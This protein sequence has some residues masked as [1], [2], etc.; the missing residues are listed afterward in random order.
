MSFARAWEAVC[1]HIDGIAAGPLIEALHEQ[2][3][4]RRVA[5]QTVRAHDLE[6]DGLTP[7]DAALSLK[8]LLTQAIVVPDGE[9]FALT[10]FGENVAA[11]PQWHRGAAQRIA[12]ASDRLAGN[13]PPFVAPQED[14]PDRIRAH[15]MGPSVAALCHILF[16]Q[17]RAPS[18]PLPVGSNGAAC[19]AA[20]G[21]V[22]AGT[23]TLTDMG[24]K[25]IPLAAQYAYPLS[26]LPTFAA[27]GA[28]ITGNG[29]PSVAQG[30]EERHVDRA[31]DIAFSGNVFS[32]TCKDPFVKALLPL[33]EGP[34]ETQP[35]AIVDTGSGD[36]TV[37]VEAFKAI[38]ST[39]RGQ[40]LA[41]HPLML[42]GVEYTAVAR[43]ST[44]ARLAV[45]DTP[46]LAVEGDIGDPQ[47]IAA[48]LAEAGM[49]PVDALHINK[50][51]LHNRTHRPPATMLAAPT[52]RAVFVDP[53][54][55]LIPTDEAFGALVALFSDWRPLIQKH[56][57]ISIEAHTVDP[58]K[59][60]QCVGRSLITSL[61][62]AHG[63]SR[64]YLMEIGVHRAAADA[65]GLTRCTQHDVGAAMMGEAIMSIDHL[66]AA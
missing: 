27:T 37:L 10:P 35:S 31:L 38:T 22:E 24:H 56:G 8:L 62:A 21:L 48:T 54:G 1:H 40:H 39:A 57:M 55:R 58:I 7:G 47:S 13:D 15:H 36:G 2:G 32:A 64:Q 33:F 34:L 65:A 43:R 61:D 63:L 45:L 19:L 17:G 42:V 28:I 26:Y 53:S 52:S 11:H 50:S 12:D 9:G 49:D 60:G 18:A 23:A 5:R 59:A 44:Q 20:A 25:A 41:T 16:G 51:V 66:I 30:G 29:A 14:W 46:S 3:V 6:A 4:F